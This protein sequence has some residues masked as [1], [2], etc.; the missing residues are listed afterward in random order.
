MSE[1]Q[2]DEERYFRVLLRSRYFV[3][4]KSL[5]CTQYHIESEALTM[6]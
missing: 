2:E 4:N 1:D 3:R 6:P 5:S